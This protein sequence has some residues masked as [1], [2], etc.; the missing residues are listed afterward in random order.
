MANNDNVD[1]VAKL[2]ELVGFD[3]VRRQSPTEELMAEIKKELMDERLQKAKAQ[4]RETLTK[5]FALA[6]QMDVLEK[7]FL[8]QKKAFNKELG[9]LTNSLN[10]SLR[11][12]PA[13][14]EGE[15]EAEEASS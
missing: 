13:Q 1:N 3:P 12:R 9:K 15:E 5:A 10:A 11:G 14:E 6:E 8:K 7:T 4:A 2:K